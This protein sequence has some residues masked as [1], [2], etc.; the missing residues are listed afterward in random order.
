MRIFITAGLVDEGIDTLKNYG[1]V[2][3]EPIRETRCMLS[4]EALLE[5]LEGID[6]FVTELDWVTADVIEKVH[7]LKAI[8]D[9]RSAP[10]NVDIEAATKHGIVVLNVPGRNAESVAELTICLMLMLARHIPRVVDFLRNRTGNET[11]VE[12]WEHLFYEMPGFELWGK[13]V[14]IIGLGAIG[15]EVSRRV[16][17]FGVHQIAYDPY[18]TGETFERCSI[19]SV[20]LDTLLSESDFITL[21]ATLTEESRKMLGEREFS[22]MKPT[23]YFINTARAALTDEHA[24]VEAL[25]EG[26]IAGAGIDVFSIEP[27]PIE[28][29]LL[30]LDN[31]IALPHIGGNPIEVPLHQTRIAVPDLER[32]L[33][34]QEPHNCVNP[35]TLKGF[36]PPR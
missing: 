7:A 30:A 14:G 21:H 24:L 34:G 8:L 6:V 9:C 1:E 26:R 13:T 20:D 28:H 11:P 3:Y 32:L 29:P 33:Q 23:A 16:N 18:V 31:V 25:K 4:G 17:P 19:R 35:E 15:Q 22:L 12:V 2:V 27:P 10:T 36:I 5:K